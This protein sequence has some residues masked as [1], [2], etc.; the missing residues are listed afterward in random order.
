MAIL[1]DVTCQCFFFQIMGRMATEPTVLPLNITGIGI[2]SINTPMKASV[3]P[4]TCSLQGGKTIRIEEAVPEDYLTIEEMIRQSAL[5]GRGFG[6]DEF[7]ENGLFNRNLLRN[8][9]A[10][11]ARLQPGGL[12]VGIALA[13][14]SAVCRV[15]SK[16]MNAY[17]VIKPT[18]RGNGVGTALMGTLVDV[19]KSLRYEG[20]LMD[21]YQTESKTI[22]WSKKMGFRVTG[23]LPE[24]GYVKGQGFVDTLLLYREFKF[25]GSKL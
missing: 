18:Y 22:S 20:M 25:D 12:P 13:G 7:T 9:H 17:I 14:A 11:V 15:E 10:V 19:A 21:V 4:V 16:L 24:S 8:S 5:E 1:N 23:S 2:K 3:L 6:L